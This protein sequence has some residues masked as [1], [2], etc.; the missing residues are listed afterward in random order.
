[1]KLIDLEISNIGNHS[2]SVIVKTVSDDQYEFLTEVVN[3]LNESGDV[4]SPTINICKVAN[5][6]DCIE[7]CNAETLEPACYNCCLFDS[8]NNKC[9][10]NALC[11]DK[12]DHKGFYRLKGM[13]KDDII[14]SYFNNLEPFK[15]TDDIPDIPITSPEIYKDIIVPNIIRCGGIPKSELKSHTV[16][17]GGCRNSSEAEW[18]GEKFIYCRHKWG[19]EYIDDVQHFEDG[20]DNTED[21]FIPIKIKE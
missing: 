8:K 12:S 14:K 13:G 16:Y 15:S 18:D 5:T 20:I 6:E 4:H 3:E 1:M 21:V 17:L 11:K 2:S 7:W 9:K 19:T 10:N